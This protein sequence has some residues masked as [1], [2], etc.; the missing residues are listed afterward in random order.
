M[1]RSSVCSVDIA[2]SR[3]NSPLHEP[4]DYIDCNSLYKASCSDNRGF[5]TSSV[6]TEFNEDFIFFEHL[7]CFDTGIQISL[8]DF[9]FF[10]NQIPLILLDLNHFSLYLLY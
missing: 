2:R 10:I 7:R 4:E 1:A 6:M 3:R 8:L 5:L 9:G